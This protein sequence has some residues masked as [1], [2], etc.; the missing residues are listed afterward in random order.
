M[1]SETPRK[2]LPSWMRMKMPGDKRYME[3]KSLVVRNRLNTICTSGNC[4][5]I[6]ECWAEGTASFM[7]LGDICTRSCKFCNVATGRPLPPDPLEPGR[8]AETMRKMGLRHAI[9]TSVD[10]DDLPDKGSGAWEATLK[11]LRQQL[12]ELTLE[13]LIPDFDGDPLLVKKITDQVPEVISHNLETVRRLSP[14]IRTKARYDISLSVL[15]Q[16]AGA[17]ITAK[18]GIMVG[19]G[20]T[21]EEVHQTM[22]DLIRA[23]CKVITIGQYLS[24]SVNHLPVTEYIHPDEF[25]EYR[26]VAIHKGFLHVEC[27]PLVRSSYR[28]NHHAGEGIRYRD[29]GVMDYKLAWD[30]QEQLFEKWMNYKR[31]EERGDPPGNYLL[32]CEHPHV[33]T[34]GKSGDHD[35]LLISDEFLKKIKAVFYR[36]DRGGDITYHGPGQLV[37]YPVLNLEDFGLGSKTYIQFLEDSVITL[38]K[39]FGL[40]GE[41]KQEATGVWLDAADP[42]RARKIC[43]IGVRLSRYVSMH[44]FALNVNTNLDYFNYINPCGFSSYGVTSIQKEIGRAINLNEVKSMLRRILTENLNRKKT[45]S[46]APP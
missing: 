19:L 10:R 18:S 22:D 12:P 39:E 16:V 40:K 3:V 37:G 6:G 43:A 29:L 42:A 7:I 27:S 34:L 1:N 4:P 23:G 15:K 2:R 20:E 17:G 35:N 8:L 36:I 11:E 5:N 38:L 26:S 13:T 14:M 45:R 30:F 46:E 44:G 24:P 21:K 9:I 28:A 41:R 33:Y 31:N 32:F 25:S